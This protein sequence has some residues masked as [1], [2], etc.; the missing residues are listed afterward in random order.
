M[1]EI[2]DVFFCGECPDFLYEDASGYGIC[3]KDN[4]RYS[5][6]QKCEYGREK[7]NNL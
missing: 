1:N 4:E 3:A 6:N 5:C 2:T 7:E